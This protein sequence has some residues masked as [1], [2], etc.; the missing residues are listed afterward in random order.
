MP[1]LANFA[2]TSTGNAN[3]NNFPTA[4]VSGQVVDSKTGALIRDFT[5]ANAVSFPAV[6]STLTAA[7]RLEL[8]QNICIWL[9]QKKG[10]L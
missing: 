3:I 2:I 9:L 6:L 7:D 5:G 8:L 4:S 10:I 1:D